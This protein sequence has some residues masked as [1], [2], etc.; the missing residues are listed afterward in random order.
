[1]NKL[2]YD[3]IANMMPVEVCREFAIFGA[4]SDR[5]IMYLLNRGQ[6]YS[7]QPKEELFTLGERSDRFYI[8]LQGKVS[9]YKHSEGNWAFLSDYGSGEQI[10]FVGMISLQPRVGWA[11]AES[12]SL[13][14]EISSDLF[15]EF[16]ME[17]PEDFSV[18]MI[19]LVREISR[20][21][22]AVGDMLVDLTSSVQ[23]KINTG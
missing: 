15:H 8:V 7:L 23:D 19:N 10:G 16:Q 9:F 13:V 1:M 5:A 6:V 18:L 20:N 17:Y 4:L 11:Y 22:I 14:L 2:R 12:D 21:L 3:D